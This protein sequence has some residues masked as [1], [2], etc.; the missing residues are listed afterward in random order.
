[1]NLEDFDD[2]QNE[3]FSAFLRNAKKDQASPFGTLKAAK[4]AESS[5]EGHT[6]LGK[7]N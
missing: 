2:D 4:Y 1:M 3:H 7:D 6:M 5:E